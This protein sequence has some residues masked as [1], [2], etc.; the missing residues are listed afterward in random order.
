MS[1]VLRTSALHAAIRPDS[2]QRPAPAEDRL[3]R[4]AEDAMRYARKPVE[5]VSA[6]CGICLVIAGSVALTGGPVGIWLSLAVVGGVLAGLAGITA[7]R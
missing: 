1:S 7:S 5:P 2:A 6:S 3:H 4:A